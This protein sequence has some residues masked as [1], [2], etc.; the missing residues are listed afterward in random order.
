LVISENLHPP[1]TATLVSTILTD[2]KSIFFGGGGVVVMFLSLFFSFI[3]LFFPEHSIQNLEELL[4][5]KLICFPHNRAFVLRN[6]YASTVV[7]VGY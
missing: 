6:V 5:I 2:F 3:A 4:T 1:Q 7:L